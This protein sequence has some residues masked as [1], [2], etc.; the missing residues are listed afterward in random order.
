MGIS[1]GTALAANHSGDGRGIRRWQMGLRLEVGHGVANRLMRPPSDLR[2]LALMI[3]VTLHITTC[4]RLASFY[5]VRARKRLGKTE[6]I[7]NGGKVARGKRAVA[8]VHVK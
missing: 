4:T 3:Q 2:T 6:V 1:G 8:G 5:A 7:P